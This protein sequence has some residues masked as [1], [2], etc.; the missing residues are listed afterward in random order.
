MLSLACKRVFYRPKKG[1]KNGRRVR[2]RSHGNHPLDSPKYQK[3]VLTW[4]FN[5]LKSMSFP[6]GSLK[7]NL[8]H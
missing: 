5:E 4:Y 8:P 6:Q 2:Y 1:S 7:N 3:K